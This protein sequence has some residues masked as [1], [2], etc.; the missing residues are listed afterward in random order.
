MSRIAY[1]SGRYLPQSQA[2]V[3]IEDR[4]YQ[5]ADGVYEVIGVQHGRLTDLR[6]HLDRLDR[7]L[8]E[9][10]MVPPIEERVL[11][12]VLERIVRLNRLGTGFVYLQ[13]TRGVAPRDHAFPAA[14]RPQLVVT[15]RRAKPA[16]PD[17][18]TEGV[19]VVTIPDIRWAR[20]DIKSV[21]LLPNVIGKQFAREHG[22]YE[23][24]QVEPDGTVTEGTSSNAWIV[25]GDGTLV[26]PPASSRIL[27]GITRIV[28]L[29]LA[30]KAGMPVEERH[31][32]VAEA[33]A[34][35]EAFLTATTVQVVPVTRIDETV[36]ANGRPGSV[37]LRL[38]D[39]MVEH[40]EREAGAC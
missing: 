35:R 39:L 18:W 9:L 30:R 36:I 15:A 37:A 1:V 26:T 34:A 25:T 14:A 23:A 19:S 31:F 7:S 33:K 40:V 32:T 17:L 12:H 22:A 11:I 13:I 27:D 21:S 16:S 38:R 3:S 5:F 6:L 29:D 28:A 24:W 10:R 4:G 20:R 2:V 8:A